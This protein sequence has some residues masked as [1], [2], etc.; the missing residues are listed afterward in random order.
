MYVREGRA[1][2]VDQRRLRGGHW[3]YNCLGGGN[4]LSTAMMLERAGIGCEWNLSSY[5]VTGA[6]WV[7]ASEC[8]SALLRTVSIFCNIGFQ[9]FDSKD[10]VTKVGF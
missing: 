10:R 9:R 8:A 4:L 6:S 3:R 2:R 1:D 7:E 5:L